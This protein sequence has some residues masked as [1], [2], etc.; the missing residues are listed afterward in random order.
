MLFAF[1]MAR[2]EEFALTANAI[3][4]QNIEQSRDKD[5]KGHLFHNAICNVP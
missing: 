3:E 5:A 4:E 2:K 1:P